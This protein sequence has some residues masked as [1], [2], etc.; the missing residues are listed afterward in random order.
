MCLYPD[1]QQRAQEELDRVIGSDRLPN[2]SDRPQ[3]QFTNNVIS[4]VLRWAPPGP[5]APHSSS[6]DNIFEGYYIPKDS[7]VFANIWYADYGNSSSNCI[8]ITILGLFCMTKRFIRSLTIL[9]R[10]AILS[11]PKIRL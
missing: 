7:T 5:L 11:A 6:K 10:I 8:A 9:I 2:I 1:I 4:E 3:L